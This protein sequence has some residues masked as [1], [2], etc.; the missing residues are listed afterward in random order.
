MAGAMLILFIF[1]LF[2]FY[3]ALGGYQKKEIEH[4]VVVLYKILRKYLVSLLNF[5]LKMRTK[6]SLIF[7]DLL[8]FLLYSGFCFN[9]LAI[10]TWFLSQIKFT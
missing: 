1:T 5:Q 10:N 2:Y 7:Y 9:H 4:K 6:H 3:W 8:Y